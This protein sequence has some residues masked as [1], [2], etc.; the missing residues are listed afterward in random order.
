HQY[1]DANSSGTAAGCVSA[2][3]AVRRVA[4]ATAW[5]RETGNRGFLGEFG[6]SRQP[7]CQAVLTAVLRHMA[8]NPEWLGWTAWASSAR[9]GSYPFNLYPF[10]QPTPPQLETL[11]PFLAR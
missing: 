4:V 2:E 5:L 3:V 8:A 6:V 10:Q 1:F 7:E 9:F 11:R